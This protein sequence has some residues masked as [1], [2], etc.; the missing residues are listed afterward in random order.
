VAVDILGDVFHDVAHRAP[1]GRIHDF[2]VKAGGN[3]AIGSFGL[4]MALAL[5]VCSVMA[6]GIALHGANQLMLLVGAHKQQQVPVRGAIVMGFDHPK[7]EILDIAAR[8]SGTAA[9]P[10]SA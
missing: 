10:E 1:F 8:Q 9:F 4:G 3:V 2:P 6:Q 5:K 7:A